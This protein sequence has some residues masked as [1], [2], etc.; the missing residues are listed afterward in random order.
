MPATI[1]ARCNV[2]GRNA[3]FHLP[4]YLQTHLEASHSAM[5]EGNCQLAKSPARRAELSRLTA[6]R[7]P[8]SPVADVHMCNGIQLNKKK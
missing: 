3:K 4:G 6:K 1:D 8:T 5:F 2:I 7:R